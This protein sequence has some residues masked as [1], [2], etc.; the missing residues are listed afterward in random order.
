LLKAEEI[1]AAGLSVL[2][3]GLQMAV[4][5]IQEKID[6]IRAQLAG[7]QKL[8]AVKLDSR[9]RRKVLTPQ[10]NGARKLRKG[11]RYG[12]SSDPEERKEQMRLRKK[13]ANASNHPRHPSHPKHAEWVEM[14]RTAQK[15][16]WEGVKQGGKAA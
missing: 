13:K 9:R 16:R 2:L 5:T 15:K 1:Q 6:E 4:V 3:P 11:G 12:W 8:P 14:M 7:L 10:K